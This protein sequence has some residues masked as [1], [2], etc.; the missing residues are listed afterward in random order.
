MKEFIKMEDLEK[1]EIDG[2]KNVSRTLIQFK[3]NKDCYGVI[4]IAQGYV[5]TPQTKY[6]VFSDKFY[7]CEIPKDKLEETMQYYSRSHYDIEVECIINQSPIQEE[8]E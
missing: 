3:E 6:S 7:L 4:L 2:Q 8:R 5:W 1:G